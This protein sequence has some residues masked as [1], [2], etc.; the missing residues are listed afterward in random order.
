M[1]CIIDARSRVERIDGL[2]KLVLIV[3]VSGGRRHGVIVV[4]IVGPHIRLPPD[5]V[6]G[7]TVAS[8]RCIGLPQT[9][10]G[11]MPAALSFEPSFALVAQAPLSPATHFLLASDQSSRAVLIQLPGAR[12]IP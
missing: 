11:L 5:Q 8:A 7:R 2:Q 9:G 4:E 3:G 6:Q 10:D 12:A 1:S